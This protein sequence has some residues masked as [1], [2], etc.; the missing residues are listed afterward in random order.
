VTFSNTYQ[1]VVALT[2]LE[3]YERFTGI[4]GVVIY[5]RSM[6]CAREIFL[7]ANAHLIEKEDA[8][9]L[10]GLCKYGERTYETGAETIY[11]HCT[12]E[13]MLNRMEARGRPSEKNAE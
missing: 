12:E 4:G 9:F 7:E 10:A 6:R 1:S 5:E 2:L 3:R 11:L 13:E 8:S